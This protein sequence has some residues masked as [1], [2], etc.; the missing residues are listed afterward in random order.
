MPGQWLHSQ[1]EVKVQEIPVRFDPALIRC[2]PTSC[3]C[4]SRQL[5]VFVNDYIFVQN[6]ESQSSVEQVI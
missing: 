3:H 2:Q 4:L 5:T 6:P 1:F